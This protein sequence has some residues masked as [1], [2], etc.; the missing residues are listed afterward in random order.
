MI[1]FFKVNPEVGVEKDI[2]LNNAM[3]NIVNFYSS[4]VLNKGEA[5]MFNGEAFE[6]DT[7]RPDCEYLRFIIAIDN[8]IINP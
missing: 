5:Y 1:W 3:I 7:I 8:R 6:G 2:V 4:P